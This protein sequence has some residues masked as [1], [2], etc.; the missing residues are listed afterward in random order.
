MSNKPQ[1]WPVTPAQYA[2][3]EAEVAAAGYPI[4]GN[5]GTT[6]VKKGPITATIGWLFDGAKLSI[7]VLSAT[8]GFTGIVEG[9]IAAAV[10]QALKS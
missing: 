6:Q 5:S 7:T 8:V 2:A 3:M 4:S 1:V 10:N 9:Q